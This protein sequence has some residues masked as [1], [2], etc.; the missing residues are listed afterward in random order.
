MEALYSSAGLARQ[1]SYRRTAQRRITAEDKPPRIAASP[2][3]GGI[4]IACFPAL[5]PAAKMFRT[6]G[7]IRLRK[8]ITI[9]SQRM[10]PL[11]IRDGLAFLRRLSIRFDPAMQ[12]QTF[13]SNYRGPST[14][15]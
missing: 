12:A 6:G 13:G 3:T 8:P 14:S 11:P 9:T 15:A 4:T 1:P 7:R 5:G 2:I 10:E